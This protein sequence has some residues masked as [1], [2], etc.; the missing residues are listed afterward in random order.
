VTSGAK[1]VPGNSFASPTVAGI[2]GL[3]WAAD[4]SLSVDRVESILLE[5]GQ[6]ATSGT[7]VP[8]RPNALAAVCRALGGCAP[9]GPTGPSPDSSANFRVT[10]NGFHCTRPTRDDALQRDGVDDEV[11]V[12]ADLSLFDRRTNRN[13]PMAQS[14]VMGDSNR[15][16]GRIRAGSGFNVFGGNGGFREGDSFPISATPWILAGAP[17]SDRP[18]LLVW[19]GQLNRDDNA[20]VVIPSLWETDN[21]MRLLDVQWTSSIAGTFSTIGPEVGLMIARRAGHTPTPELNTTLRRLFDSV[22]INEGNDPKDRPV[23]M[24]DRGEQ[25][26]YM[27][28]ALI[29]TFDAADRLSRTDFGLGAGILPLTFRDQSDFN[30]DYTLYVQVQRMP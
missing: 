10:I 28:Q 9:T 24:D 5:T 11:F 7:D 8:L 30:G 17:T 13:Q 16:P 26:G 27:P 2:A 15:Q 25:L 29:L 21:D 23:G 18:P 12:R 3:I 4:P 6:R 1:K 19:T 22:R 14:L 20:L